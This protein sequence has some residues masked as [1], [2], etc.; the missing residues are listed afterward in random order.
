MVWQPHES[1]LQ[2]D[3]H[4][5]F[6]VAFFF[7]NTCIADS[8]IRSFFHSD[9]FNVHHR[10]PSPP[11]LHLLPA[12]RHDRRHD[13]RHRRL[14]LHPPTHRRALV[15]AAA[16]PHPPAAAFIHGQ[17]HAMTSCM[18]RG[19]P[20]PG[21]PRYLQLYRLH[22]SPPQSCFF[23]NDLKL[24]RCFAASCPCQP[25]NCSWPLHNFGTG[26]KRLKSWT[27][28]HH[29]HL[30]CCM[31][32]YPLLA[33]HPSNGRLMFMHNPHSPSPVLPPSSLP[34]PVPPPSP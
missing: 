32:A 7:E 19:Q 4:A 24:A 30:V 1:A 8:Q 31:H 3:R 26:R 34:V 33:V 22:T 15:S 18:H 10:P 5:W 27:L 17:Q 16:P 21:A 12:P 14:P 11:P 13:H 29:P 25:C 23:L 20:T 2:H 6:L 9:V 28:T